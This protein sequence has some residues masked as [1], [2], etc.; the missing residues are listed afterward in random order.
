MVDAPMSRSD[1]APIF[2]TDAFKAAGGGFVLFESANGAGLEAPGGIGH[3]RIGEDSP[4]RDQAGMFARRYDASPG[5]AYLLRPDG[6]VAARFKRP[7]RAAIEAALSRAS[8][9]A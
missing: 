4:L 9:W 1:G 6:Y 8:G 2:L 7:T 5:S 3:L